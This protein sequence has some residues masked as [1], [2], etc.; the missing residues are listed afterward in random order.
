MYIVEFVIDI[1]N[2]SPNFSG[3]ILLIS[4]CSKGDAAI[5]IQFPI[6]CCL[7]IEDSWVSIP[8]PF[9]FLL[10]TRTNLEFLVGFHFANFPHRFLDCPPA[11][12][13]PFG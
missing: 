5:P 7:N 1:S 3:I 10:Y 11:V 4:N 2:V 13:P 6:I 12:L 8:F 9:F